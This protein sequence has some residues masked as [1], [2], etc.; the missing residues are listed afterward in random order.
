[1][2]RV[3]FR[4]VT[5][6]QAQ[7][8]VIARLSLLEVAIP[9]LCRVSVLTVFISAFLTNEFDGM[10]FQAPEF[11]PGLPAGTQLYFQNQTLFVP[12]RVQVD[13]VGHDALTCN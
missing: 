2:P 7:V 3:V 5:K 1:M 12:S 8:S 10:S 6:A 13:V 4:G 11:I 9:R